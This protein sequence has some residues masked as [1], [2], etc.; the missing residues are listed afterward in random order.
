MS[1][2]PYFTDAEKSDVLIKPDLSSFKVF[3]WALEGKKVA[4]VASVQKIMNCHRQKIPCKSRQ[5]D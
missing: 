1:G 3:P 2:H 4:G 5:I